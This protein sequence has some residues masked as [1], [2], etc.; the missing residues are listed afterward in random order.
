MRYIIRSG[1][2][3]MSGLVLF[4][5]STIV[6]RVCRTQ[7]SLQLSKRGAYIQRLNT[8][9]NVSDQLAVLQSRADKNTHHTRGKSSLC[10]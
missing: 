3:A 6:V 9:H 7:L 4:V 10:V 8:D 1:V 5:I 2:K